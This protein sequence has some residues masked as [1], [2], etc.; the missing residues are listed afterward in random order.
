MTPLYNCLRGGVGRWGFG[1]LSQVTSDMTRGNSL[2]L[3]QNWLKLDIRKK[4]LHQKSCQGMG[5]AGTWWS[6]PSGGV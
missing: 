3:F 5:S 4:V 1:I 2:K 6:H